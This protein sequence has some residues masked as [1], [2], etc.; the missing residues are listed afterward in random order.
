[1]SDELE[2][3]RQLEE[4]LS[5]VLAEAERAGTLID[6]RPY[7]DGGTSMLFCDAQR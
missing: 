4:S 5:A 3:R 1:M 6:R 2:R 7:G